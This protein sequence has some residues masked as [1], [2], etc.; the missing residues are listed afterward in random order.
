MCEHKAAQVTINVNIKCVHPLHLLLYTMRVTLSQIFIRHIC[1]RWRHSQGHQQ[2]VN[3]GS[4][5]YGPDIPP[6]ARVFESHHKCARWALKK[7]ENNECKAY[8][9]EIET[10]KKCVQLI[11]SLTTRKQ[12]WMTTKAGSSRAHWFLVSEERHNTAS[13]HQPIRTLRSHIA[14]QVACIKTE[15]DKTE[16]EP[17]HIY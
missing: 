8:E 2:P 7:E 13:Q 17:P 9:I 15:N 12:S 1:T 14:C 6:E 3:H 5:H 10:N 11:L 4:I 16:A